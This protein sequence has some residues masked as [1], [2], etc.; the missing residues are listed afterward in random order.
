MGQ[1]QVGMRVRVYGANG[2]TP[3][4]LENKRC[5]RGTVMDFIPAKSGSRAAVVQL[6]EPINY[7]GTK[8]N[9]LV[10]EIPFIDV[11][12]TEEEIVHLELIEFLPE[13]KPFNSRRHGVFI[14][15]PATYSHETAGGQGIFGALK[16][17][18]SK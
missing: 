18:F 2:N 17:L 14:N 9:V 16:N 5:I 10:M 11:Q 1:L 4:W 3:E 7:S 15:G 8:G 13:K 12:W 6:D